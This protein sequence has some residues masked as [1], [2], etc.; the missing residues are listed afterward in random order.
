M[1]ET[2]FGVVREVSRL[3]VNSNVTFGRNYE[4]TSCADLRS[5]NNNFWGLDNWRLNVNLGSLSSYLR[6][7]N[8]RH[9]NLRG[10]NNNLGLLNMLCCYNYLWRRVAVAVT[11]EEFRPKMDASS[12]LTHELDLDPLLPRS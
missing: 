7:Q 9:L 6:M 3:D 11:M 5:L 2:R 8:G 1:E 12:G 4:S 10:S